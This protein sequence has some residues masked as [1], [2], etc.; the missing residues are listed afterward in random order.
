M[1]ELIEIIEEWPVIIQGALGS[2]LFASALFVAQKVF[3]HVNYQISAFSNENR[4]VELKTEKLKVG[5]AAARGKDKAIFAAPILYRMSRPFLKGLV[6]LVL[7]L[8]LGEI[9]S[10]LSMVGY[11]GSFYYL[12]NALNVVS[13]Y[14]LEGDYK[15]KLDQ[16]NRELDDLESNT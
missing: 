15:P 10:G 4:I 6:W 14:E 8:M 13:P 5:L 7:G 3:K 11:A 16:I 12:I 9:S 1:P 2:A